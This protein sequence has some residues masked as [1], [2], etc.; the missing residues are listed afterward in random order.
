MTDT[1]VVQRIRDLVDPIASDLELDLYDVEQRGGTMRVTLDTPP[2]SEAGI[3]LD[4][5][6]LATRLIS[7]ELDHQD[8]VPGRYTLEV[9]SPGVERSLRTPAH[10]QREVGKTINV[11]L[12][13]VDADQRRLEGVLVAAD[14]GT[15]T[16][17]L[18]GDDGGE[19]ERTIA[20]DEID[21]A[22]T[23][24]VWGPKPKPGGKG[25]GKSKGAGKK[26]SPKQQ[27]SKKESS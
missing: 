17:R 12:A 15:A 21:R 7:R 5:L 4:K 6:A 25:A 3:D 14:E 26:K 9:T 8:P 2:G 20:I 22:R 11:R 1:P 24:F 27:Q 23:V 13:N 10:F 18:D 16:L 19:V